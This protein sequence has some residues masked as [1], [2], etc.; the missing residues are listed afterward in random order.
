[1]ELRPCVH[2]VKRITPGRLAIGALH[3]PA[4]E[5]GGRQRW[6]ERRHQCR[7]RLGLLHV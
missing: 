4:D 7:M 5:G 1:M 3:C 2:P 6:G